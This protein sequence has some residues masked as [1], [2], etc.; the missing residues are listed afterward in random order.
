MDHEAIEAELNYDE[1]TLL[2]R[3]KDKAG[4]LAQLIP[5]VN[6]HKFE[7]TAETDWAHLRV[8]SF[9]DDGWTR[10]LGPCVRVRS[11]DL[12]NRDKIGQIINPLVGGE[13]PDSVLDTPGGKAAALLFFC[14][15]LPREE[16]TEVA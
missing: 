7:R 9:L 16:V 12:L 1:L 5:V 8:L 10:G 13:R 3:R 11:E 14:A 6:R 2:A 4:L 15:T